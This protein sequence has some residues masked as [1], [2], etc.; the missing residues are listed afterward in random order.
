MAGLSIGKP[1]SSEK[2]NGPEIVSKV[3][4]S[5]GNKDPGHCLKELE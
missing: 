2:V 5:R 4:T 1:G 3:A